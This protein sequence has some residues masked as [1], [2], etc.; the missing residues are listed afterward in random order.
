MGNSPPTLAGLTSPDPESCKHDYSSETAADR[1]RPLVLILHSAA[2]SNVDL[3]DSYIL[4]ASHA[5]DNCRLLVSTGHLH[6]LCRGD[7]FSAM[8]VDL[9]CGVVGTMD[10]PVS[11]KPSHAGEWLLFISCPRSSTCAMSQARSNQHV[12]LLS[13]V[14]ALRC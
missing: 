6:A 14:R 5:G 7:I 3:S 13:W 4:A 1:I 12:H 8:L 2:D 10:D 11:G 9:M